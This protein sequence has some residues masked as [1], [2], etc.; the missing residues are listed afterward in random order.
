M[1]NDVGVGEGEDIKEPNI[2][3]ILWLKVYPPFIILCVH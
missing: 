2:N 3:W 1:E